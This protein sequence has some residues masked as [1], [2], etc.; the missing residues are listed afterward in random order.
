[1]RF[2]E[3]IAYT[4]TLVYLYSMYTQTNSSKFY[5]SLYEGVDYSLCL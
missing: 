3:P 1:M 2:V 5:V 4:K